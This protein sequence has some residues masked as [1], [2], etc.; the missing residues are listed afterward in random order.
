MLNRFVVLFL[1]VLLLVLVLSALGYAQ[2]APEAQFLVAANSLRSQAGLHELA[3]DVQL[4]LVAKAWAVQMAATGKLEHNPAMPNA[5]VGQWTKAGENVGDGWSVQSIEAAFE[6]S[7]P[8]RA[9]ILGDFTSVGIGTAV[10]SAGRLWVTEDF[11]KRVVY[12]PPLPSR[13]RFIPRLAERWEAPS[14]AATP[15]PVQPAFT[16]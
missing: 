4:D 10:D 13:R 14:A 15:V 8:H 9:N 5:V 16:G 7:P 3:R 11:V 2:D 1:V 6:A 12:L